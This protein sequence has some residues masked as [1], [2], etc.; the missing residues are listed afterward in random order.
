[1]WICRRYLAVAERSIHT[2]HTKDAGGGH[3][4]DTMKIAGKKNIR[5]P[6]PILRGHL[7]LIR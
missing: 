5:H 4:H 7:L 1:M 2:Y 3:A 6:L